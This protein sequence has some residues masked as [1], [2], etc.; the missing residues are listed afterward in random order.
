MGVARFAYTPLLPIMQAETWLN[1]ASG[2]WLATINYIGYFVGALIAAS[3]TDLRKKDFIYR[4]GLILAV[5]S[6]AAMGLTD[7]MLLWSALRFIA[8]LTSAAGLLIGSGLIMN[9]LLRN[10]YRSE[11]GLHFSG[12]GLGIVLVSICVHF[13]EESF[14]WQ[15]QWLLLALLSIGLLIPAW[16]WLPRPD[17]TTARNAGVSTSG[18]QL[19]D[20]PP[21]KKFI[22][23]VMLAYFCAGIGYVISATF[24]VTIVERQPGLQ[25]QGWLAFLIVGLAATPACILWDRIARSMGEMRALFYAYVF[26]ILGLVLPFIHSSLFIT[27]LSAALYGGTFVG[28]VSLMLSMVGRFYPAKPATL[29]GKLT[30]SFGVAQILGPAVAGEIAEK[31]GSYNY[32]LWMAVIIMVIGALLIRSLIQTYSLIDVSVQSNS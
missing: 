18:E 24:I 9:W 19:V 17:Q 11:L 26:Q 23:L 28:I 2:G 27:I 20:R 12:V 30:L 6:T 5:L 10:H 14:D 1:D 32:P 29:M 31:T 16:R 13:F 15:T 4:A 21:S 8:G 22:Y 3:I 7:N 25:G